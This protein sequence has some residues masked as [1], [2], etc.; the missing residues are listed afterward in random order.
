MPPL[1]REQKIQQ[2]ELLEQKI[3]ALEEKKARSLD[4]DSPIMD[5][6]KWV[7]SGPEGGPGIFQDPVE[8]LGSGPSL[9]V[10]A[11]R[12][13]GGIVGGATLGA[14]E[15]FKEE[16]AGT[17]GAGAGELVGLLAPLGAAYKVGGAVARG[18]LGPVQ[19]FVPTLSRF[20]TGGTAGAITGTGRTWCRS[21]GEGDRKKATE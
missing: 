9:G 16:I 14:I 1:T 13:G 4:G 10:A 2:V 7:F 5:A 15:P 21:V 18:V 8:W 19:R 11:K 12:V 6:V 20:L 17:A 3:A